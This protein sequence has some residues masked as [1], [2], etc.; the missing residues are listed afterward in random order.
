MA[1][2]ETA[3]NGIVVDGDNNNDDKDM[4]FKVDETGE[5]YEEKGAVS[6]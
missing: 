5:K 2:D 1:Q 3:G 4:A 6:K